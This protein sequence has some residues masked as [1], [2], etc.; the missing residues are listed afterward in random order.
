M[1]RIPLSVAASV[2]GLLALSACGSEPLTE[3]SF[4]SVADL[5][6]AVTDQDLTCD[7]EDVVHGDGYKESM[8]CGDNVWLILFEDEQQKNARV[9]QYEESNSSYVDGPNW[10]VVAPQAELDRITN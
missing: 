10:V 8:S 5:R 9:D 2:V 1:R 4:D 3:R 6:S 7:S